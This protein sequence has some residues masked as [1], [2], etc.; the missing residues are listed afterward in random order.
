MRSEPSAFV[1]GTLIVIGDRA[2][3]VSGYGLAWRF[4]LITCLVVAYLA[5]RNSVK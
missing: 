3:S 1:I 5:V 2:A 4:A